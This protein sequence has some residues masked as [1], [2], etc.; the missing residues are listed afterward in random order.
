MSLPFPHSSFT[1][2][3]DL[4]GICRILTTRKFRLNFTLDTNVHFCVAFGCFYFIKTYTPSY[5]FL[6]SCFRKIGLNTILKTYL[7]LNVNFGKQTNSEVSF[8]HFLNL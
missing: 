1:S 6:I 5:C 3:A 2:F 7:Y 8:A 4:T